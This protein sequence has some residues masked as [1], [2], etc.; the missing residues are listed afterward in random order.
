MRR[1]DLLINEARSETDNTIFT[2][3][4]GIQDPQFIRWA[5]SAQTRILSLIQQQHPDYFQRENIITVVA[6]TEGYDLP[7]KTFLNTRVQMVEY[8]VSG[9]AV[10]YRLLKKGSL[11]ER[12]S[13][14]QGNPAF[15]IRFSDQIL[16]QP[17]PQGSGTLRVVTQLA[18]PRIDI[19]RATVLSSTLTTDTITNLTLDTGVNI[20]DTE[21][22]DEGYICIV[23]KDGAILMEGIPVDDVNT[24][25]GIVSVTAGFLF[26]SGESIPAGSYVVLGNYSSTHS[27]LP[28]VAERYLV[29]TMIWK[30]EKRDANQISQEM[31]QELK[32]IE[33]D[34]LASYAEADDD[35]T[36]VPIIDGQYMDFNG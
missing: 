34:I 24:T 13:G 32:E 3:D 8:S 7:A 4:T 33:A 22:R 2:D 17:I 19:R 18:L 9:Q 26:Q 31:N 20:D 11:K 1:L 35:V 14:T 36:F 23:D 25:T 15:Y 16:L 10:D 28:D 29:E 30:S 6:G 21:I 5:N 27:S 12:V